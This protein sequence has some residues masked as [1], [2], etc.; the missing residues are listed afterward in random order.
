MSVLA[1]TTT[2]E[3]PNG[4]FSEDFRALLE[5]FDLYTLGE[6][7][8]PKQRAPLLKILNINCNEY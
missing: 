1:Q 6:L 2:A 8:K 3:P 5:V 7:T 4:I